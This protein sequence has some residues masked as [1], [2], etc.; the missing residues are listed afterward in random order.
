MTDEQRD[1]LN[2][3]RM[4]ASQLEM[5]TVPKELL[6]L[7]IDDAANDNIFL[8]IF[9][10]EF[11]RYNEATDGVCSVCQSRIAALRFIAGLDE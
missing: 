6:R 9:L 8:G 2:R 1:E 4:K 10:G 7:V 11:F 5:V 3:D